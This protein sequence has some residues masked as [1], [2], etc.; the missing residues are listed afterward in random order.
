[1]RL[2]RPARLVATWLATLALLLAA[3]APT[4]THALAGTKAA[5][6]WIEVCSAE[7]SRWLP[8][9]DH[10]GGRTSAHTLEHCPYC[11][12]QSDLPLLPPAPPLALPPALA[13]MPVRAAFLSASRTLHAWATAQ[14]RAPPRFS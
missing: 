5:A 10:D 9:A 12:L 7:G 1:M 14:P 8:A 3:L 13:A 11:S 4:L 6:A 2:R